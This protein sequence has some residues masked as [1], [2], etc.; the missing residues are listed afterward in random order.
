MEFSLFRSLYT[1]QKMPFCVV[2]KT[3]F[4]NAKG[5]LLNLKGDPVLQ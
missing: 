5:H 2:K 4:Y 3:V 1:H